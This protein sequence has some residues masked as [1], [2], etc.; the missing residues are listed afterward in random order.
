MLL[1]AL[2]LQHG[3]LVKY[4]SDRVSVP[5][6]PKLCIP[7]LPPQ[8]IKAVLCDLRLRLCCKRTWER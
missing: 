8:R 5:F 1:T 6:L 7:V 3:C 4:A 2:Q